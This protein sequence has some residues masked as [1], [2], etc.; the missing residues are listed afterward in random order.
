[1]A[2][3]TKQLIL[4]ISAP[5]LKHA[6]FGGDAKSTLAAS[7]L[8]TTNDDRFDIFLAHACEDEEI[9]LGT[10][11]MLEL[12]GHRVYVDCVDNPDIGNDTV[13]N[14]RANKMKLRM[15]A[16]ACLLFLTTKCSSRSRWMP[17]L[18][19]YFDAHKPGQVAIMP[20]MDEEDASFHG[21]GFLSLYPLAEYG[22]MPWK[23]HKTINIATADA[24]R[25]ELDRFV[26]AGKVMVAH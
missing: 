16:S 11:I 5:F 12:F 1:M 24:S 7:S 22:L 3:L 18:L 25:I 23:F 14:A 10:K 6:Q 4:T 8:A 13:S 2:F 19:G 17:W 21:K 15:Q 9:V 26:E 20:L